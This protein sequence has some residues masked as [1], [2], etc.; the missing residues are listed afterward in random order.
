M[1]Q[2]L[3][4]TIR[5][6]N[7]LMVNMGKQ[8][9]FALVY[10][11]LGIGYAGVTIGKSP[12]ALISGRQDVLIALM[13]GAPIMMAILVTIFEPSIK[14]IFDMALGDNKKGDNEKQPQQPAQKA[15]PA[16]ETA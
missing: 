8:F 11:S 6:F 14:L 10:I 4:E 5:N 15:E 7:E 12:T 9:L 1:K 16:R 2:I 13:F 3:N